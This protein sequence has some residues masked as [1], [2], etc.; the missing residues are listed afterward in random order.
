MSTDRIAYDD[1]L[2]RILRIAA[3]VFAEKGYHQASIR[4]ISRATGVSLSGLYYYVESK[5]ELLFRI[6]EHSFGTLLA[7]LDEL[8]DGVTDPHRRLRLL[9]ENHLRFFV[10]NMK[11][12]KV[13]SHEADSLSGEPRKRI[14]AMKR[15][16]SRVASGI[17][18]ELADGRPGIDLRVAT[19]SLFGM[20]NWIYNWYRPGRDV[21][22]EELADDISRLF[23]RGFLGTREEDMPPGAA[24]A[25]PGE[26]RPS[27]WRR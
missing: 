23:L 10:G 8:L 9:V 2:E 18:E 16:Y 24:Q 14:E 17:V 4:D 26:A 19:F 1:K 3:E 22:V 7:N 6:Q 5:E 20:M 27:I 13:L 25:A 11:E 15:R 12:M 21:P